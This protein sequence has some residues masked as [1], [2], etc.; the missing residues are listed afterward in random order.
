MAQETAIATQSVLK[1]RRRLPWYLEVWPRLL[2]EKPLGM[3][4]GIIVLVMLLMAILAPWLAPYPYDET[5]FDVTL[6]PPSR[7]YLLGTDVL[8]R[9]I[10][11]RVIWGARVSMYV[12][13][14]AVAVGTAWS[15]TVG[16]LSGYF[17]GTFDIVVQRFVDA[18]MS[19]PGIVLNIT[20]VAIFSGGERAPTA[21]LLSIAL[22]LSFRGFVSE[23]RLVRASAI[24]LKETAFVES[25]RAIGA[26]QLRILTHYILP[27][28]MPIIIVMSSIAFGAIIL[29]ESTLSFLG[30][31]IPPP[32]PSWGSMLGGTAR[33]YFMEG[34]WLAV[35]PGLAICLAVFGW[36]MFGDGLRDLLDPRLRGGGGRYR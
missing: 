5:H 26:S 8:G 24:T 29:M 17:G 9:D 15:A 34:P 23:T 30:Y 25:A 4:G 32:F 35:F 6:H 13:L 20:L 1:E 28:V 33:E 11:S 31:G 10:L 18:L 21:S 2:R 7:Q 22:I 3:L 36:N 19:F 27:N 16:I 14:I 12:A